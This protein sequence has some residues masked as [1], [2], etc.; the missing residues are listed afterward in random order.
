MRHVVVVEQISLRATH[1]LLGT[2]V[3]QS[4]LVIDSG[5][6]H[7]GVNAAM[8]LNGFLDYRVTVLR[9]GEFCQDQFAPGYLAV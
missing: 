9:L 7:Q 2:A 4:N 6:V 5:V 3:L 1:V 8:F